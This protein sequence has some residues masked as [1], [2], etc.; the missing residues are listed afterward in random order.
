M[1]PH[2]RPSI[3]LPAAPTAFSFHT[4]HHLNPAKPTSPTLS[5]LVPQSNR[6]AGPEVL[7]ETRWPIRGNCFCFY[8]YYCLFILRRQI[9]LSSAIVLIISPHCVSSRPNEL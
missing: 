7:P 1:T 2:P 6:H 3:I 5:S 8:Y 9:I 4:L